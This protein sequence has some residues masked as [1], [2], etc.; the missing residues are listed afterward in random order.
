MPDGGAFDGPLGVVSGFAA[1]D[2]LRDKGFRP[3]R[4]I[5]VVAFSDE[6]GARFGVACAGSRLMTGQLD[7]DRAAA[8]RD[9]DGVSM[10][11]AMEKAGYDTAMLGRD[12]Q[13]LRRIGAFVELHIEQG[14]GLVDL[15]ATIAVGT[16]IWPHGRW[17]FEFAGEANHAGTTRLEDRQ[18]AMLPYAAA[19]LAARRAAERHGAVATFGRVRVEPNGTNAIPSRVSAWL[20]A[21]GPDEEAV[22]AV[23]DELRTPDATITEESWTADDGVRCGADRPGARRARRRP[24]PAHR[25]RS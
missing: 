10:A 16:G 22:R 9:A 23:V 19:V 20:D 6:E 3:T 25:G 24:R 11:E 8:L 17:L 14:R 5:G 13:A 1:L 18:D 15:G 12:D 2:A 21:R 7:P 4:P